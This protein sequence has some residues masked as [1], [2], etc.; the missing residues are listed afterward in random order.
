MA[1]VVRRTHIATA[2]IVGTI[3]ERM[4][5]ERVTPGSEALIGYTAAELLGQPIV[6][7]VDE[8]SVTDLLAAFD[9]A[10]SSSGGASRNVA[11]RI[12]TGAAVPFEVL[13]VALLPARSIAFAFTP[14]GL[15]PLPTTETALQRLAQRLGGVWDPLAA[16]ANGD[17]LGVGQLTAREMEIVT[18]LA[19]GDRVPSIS[20]RLFLSQS[21]IRSHL[22]TIFRKFDVQSQSQLLD[23]LHGSYLD[24]TDRDRD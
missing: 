22:S 6:D 12:K 14:A 24:A 17:P 15:D 9:E 4:L 7:F 23:L 21:T 19:S 3:D 8:A 16:Q 1:G 5:I 13:V 10:A 2:N 11:V 20:G 18:L